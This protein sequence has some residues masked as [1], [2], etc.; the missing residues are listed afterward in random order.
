[1]NKERFPIKELP[2]EELVERYLS[3]PDDKVPDYEVLPENLKYLVKRDEEE[4]RELGELVQNGILEPESV[5]KRIKKYSDALKESHPRYERAI[6]II[7]LFNRGKIWIAHSMFLDKMGAQRSEVERAQEK[8][9]RL[10]LRTS[11]T[12]GVIS[13]LISNHVFNA[14]HTSGHRKQAEMIAKKSFSGMLLTKNNE[15]AVKL[16]QIAGEKDPIYFNEGIVRI[17]KNRLEKSG[18]N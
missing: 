10:F 4:A 8:T 13:P 15:E 5:D 3:L 11:L 17:N 1:M 2:I 9:A 6:D 18:L 14:L 16:A 12:I 7:Y